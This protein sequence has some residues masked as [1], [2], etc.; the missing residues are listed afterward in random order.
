MMIL[1]EMNEKS[2]LLDLIEEIVNQGGWYNEAQNRTYWRIYVPLGVAGTCQ[3]N[4]VF[5][6]RKST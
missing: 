3:G 6:G 5:G 2:K 1:E 4:I